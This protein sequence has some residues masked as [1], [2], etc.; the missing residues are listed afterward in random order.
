MVQ[1]IFISSLREW[2]AEIKLRHMVVVPRLGKTEF[3]TKIM[4]VILFLL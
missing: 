1:E 2:M 4:A 3:S